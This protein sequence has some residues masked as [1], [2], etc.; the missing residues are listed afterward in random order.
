[1][2]R[3]VHKIWGKIKPFTREEDKNIIEHLKDN[4]DK[5]GI[6][7][8]TD[9]TEPETVWQRIGKGLSE[10]FK[11]IGDFFVEFFVFIVVSLPYLVIFAVIAVAI[12]VL[13]KRHRKHKKTKENKE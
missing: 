3:T 2:E 13:I 12:I 6:D 7:R 5:D 8:F 9:V 4:P 11:D 10:S 1:M